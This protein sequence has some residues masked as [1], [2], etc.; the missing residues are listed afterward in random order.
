MNF[1]NLCISCLFTRSL[2]RLLACSLAHVSSFCAVPCFLQCDGCSRWVH[3]ACDPR[4]KAT[5]GGIFDD[6]DVKYYCRHCEKKGASTEDDDKEDSATGDRATSA[7]SSAAGLPS[8]PLPLFP[9]AL[10]ILVLSP[11]RKQR[12]EAALEAKLFAQAAST[13]RRL[14]R[15]ARGN[16]GGGN[17]GTGGGASGGGGG[18]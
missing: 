9:D 13:G 12:R 2:A 7:T 17:S 1:T 18:G 11:E 4:I 6:P 8:I 14:T 3:F 15:R 16:G 5:A 10:R